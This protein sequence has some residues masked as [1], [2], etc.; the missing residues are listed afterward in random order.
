MVPVYS[1]AEFLGSLVSEIER[2]RLEWSI[3][4]VPC[5]V[6]EVIFVDHS[7]IDSSPLILDTLACDRPWITVLHLARNYGQHAAT[8]AR[9]F[10]FFR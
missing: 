4:K 3:L 8:I 5:R 10:T 2:I 7:A 6:N 9:Y 1:G